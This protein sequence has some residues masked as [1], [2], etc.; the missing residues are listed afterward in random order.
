[1]KQP[2]FFSK[3]VFQPAWELPKNQEDS[4]ATR[5]RVTLPSISPQNIFKSLQN[6]IPLRPLTPLIKGI[7]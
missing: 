2:I 3:P 6:E 5:L 1:M 4:D 7:A